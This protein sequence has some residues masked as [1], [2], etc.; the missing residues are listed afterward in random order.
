LAQVYKN[1]LPYMTSATIPAV[2]TLRSSLSMF[3]LFGYNDF[4]LIACFVNSSPEGFFFQT[5]LVISKWQSVLI[6]S[7]NMPKPLQTIHLQFI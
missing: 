6:H 7:T 1:L 5:A 4:F 2:D 3:T